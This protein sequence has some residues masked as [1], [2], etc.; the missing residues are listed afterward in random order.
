MCAF[1][2]PAFLDNKKETQLFTGSPFAAPSQELVRESIVK[3]M[4]IDFDRL[5]NWNL[6]IVPISIWPVNPRKSY[7][8]ASPEKSQLINLNS[9]L[10]ILVLTVCLHVLN[11]LHFSLQN[12]PC[13]RHT[14]TCPPPPSKL[15]GLPFYTNVPHPPTPTSSLPRE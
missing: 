6:L 14:L 15:P 12:P 2:V 8:R 9:L 11:S 1:R 5:I 3:I 10:L 13:D 4:K 7:S